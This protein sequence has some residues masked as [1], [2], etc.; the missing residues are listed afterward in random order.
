MSNR[1]KLYGKY[2]IKHTIDGVK[3]ITVF[4]NTI[5]NNGVLT[6]LQ[7]FGDIKTTA[8]IQFIALGTGSSSAT[9]ADIK[10]DA[11]SFRKPPA[12]IAAVGATLTA[13]QVL[14]SDETNGISISEIGVYGIDATS[15][16]DS[17]V[18]I[19]RA[20]LSTPIEKQS[21]DVIDITWELT[22]S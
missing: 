20:V 10:L 14:E 8:G 12:T 21:G 19:S 13:T 16:T 5:T 9:V 6:I 1:L 15:A 22:L 2:T 3:H 11:E 17:G 7:K 18:L 4:K